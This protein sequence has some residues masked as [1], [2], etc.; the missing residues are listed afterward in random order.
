MFRTHFVPPLLLL[1]LALT[2][3]PAGLAAAQ[4]DAAW[5]LIYHYDQDRSSLSLHDLHWPGPGCLIAFG[6]ETVRGR[7]KPVAAIS[8]D[9]GR[10][11]ALTPLKAHVRSAF[12]L[13]E[14][15]GWS[16]TSDG[17]ERTSDC[18]R[19]WEKAGRQA[20]LARVWFRDEALGWG[21]GMG[22]KAVVTRDG[23]RTWKNIEAINGP[24]SEP[25]QSLFAWIAFANEQTG[26]MT[27]WHYP[28]RNPPPPPIWLDPA[29]L[30]LTVGLPYTTLL[31]Q[32]R[33]GGKTW[34]GM[35][36]SLHGRLTRLRFGPDGAGLAIIEY[37]QSF[38]WPSQVYGWR[39]GESDMPRV[40]REEH[41]FVTDAA[42]G[43]DGWTYLA[44]VEVGGSVRL[45]TPAK[46]KIVRSRD[47]KTWTP[48]RVDYRAAA[49]Y[50]WFAHGPDRELL[51]LSDRGMILR[52]DLPA[53]ARQ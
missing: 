3:A 13:T 15:L 49:E 47:L 19:T 46:V 41:H 26:V 14:R 48:V 52:L 18:G 11:W 30:R 31:L 27:G 16:V 6:T 39:V 43:R 35:T 5:K 53:P 28:D 45:P 1:L 36:A 33:D 51:A 8:R 10:T 32:T 17:V 34:R 38:Q 7:G 12:F 42:V 37:E 25:D 40:Y 24:D 44:G 23:G 22:R 2:A 29:E 20:E 21:V 4:P 50:V 9:G